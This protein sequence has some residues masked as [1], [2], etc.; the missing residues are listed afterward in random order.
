MA[1]FTTFGMQKDDKLIFVC[2][3]IRTRC[4][5]KRWF[6]KDGVKRV[7]LHLKMQD[8][9][10]RKK[11]KGEKKIAVPMSAKNIVQCP[12]IVQ[13]CSPRTNVH[14]DKY[15]KINSREINFSYMTP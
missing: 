10:A 14:E 11:N 2:G 7:V 15:A 9:P 13:F 6:P 4:Y 1:F 3:C 12:C 8:L 5:A